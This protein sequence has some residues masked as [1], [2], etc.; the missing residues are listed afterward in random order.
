MKAYQF[1]CNLCEA[2]E[3]IEAHDQRV[4]WAQARRRGWTR[5]QSGLYRCPECSDRM[6]SAAEDVD[7]E[8]Y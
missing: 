4:A 1:Q 8:N 7:P 6:E 5:P 3:D 2:T